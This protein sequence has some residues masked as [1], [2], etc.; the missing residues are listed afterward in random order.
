M[1]RGTKVQV[2]SPEMDSSR[3]SEDDQNEMKL[4]TKSSK[5][6]RMVNTLNPFKKK[7]IDHIYR[8]GHLPPDAKWYILDPKVVQFL[9]CLTFAMRV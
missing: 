1:G 2:Q 3:S 5:F 7:K 6:L 9:P 8:R 4:K